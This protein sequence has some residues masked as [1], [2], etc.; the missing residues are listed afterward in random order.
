MSVNA[1]VD[2]GRVVSV[3]VQLY[4]AMLV[5]AIAVAVA[6]LLFP[7]YLANPLVGGTWFAVGGYGVAVLILLVLL[8]TTRE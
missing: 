3:T 1:P 6:W 8:A 4:A 5:V 7:A 2:F